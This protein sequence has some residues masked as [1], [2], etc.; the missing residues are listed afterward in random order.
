MTYKLCVHG[1]PITPNALLRQLAGSSF[2]VSYARPDQLAI[3]EELVGDHGMLLLDNGTYTIAARGGRATREDFAG[4]WR[5]ALPILDRC[6]QAIA[7]IPDVIGGAEEENWKLAAEAL[8]QHVP[9]HLSGKLMFVW[10][11][12]GSEEQLYR[13]ARLF[14]FVGIGGL[15]GFGRNAKADP[16]GILELPMRRAMS[17]IN[18]VAHVHGRRPWIHI[19]RGLAAVL[20]YVD[21]QSAD[22]ASVG[23][24][25]HRYLGQPDHVA[26]YA[27]RFLMRANETR[28]LDRLLIE[29]AVMAELG[30]LIEEPSLE[31]GT[32][33]ELCDAIEDQ[34]MP[35]ET[36]QQAVVRLM[37]DIDQPE[38]EFLLT[39]A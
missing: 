32:F 33:N 4:F 5:W 3:C 11:L 9:H 13:A 21:A 14:N 26:N 20:P 34:M 28:S 31:E 10:H 6:P 35:G 25:H 12:G 24:N 22:A 19:L 18:T 30:R 15:L 37:K 17:V 8:H 1:T 38:H 29:E 2:C 16:G 27:G 7:I 39:A 23:R 36:A